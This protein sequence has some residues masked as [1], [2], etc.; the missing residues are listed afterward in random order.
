MMHIP[1]IKIDRLIRSKRKTIALIVR[2]DGTLVVRAP[3]RASNQQI[4][5]FVQEKAKWIEA[6]QELIRL[7]DQKSLHK[8]YVDGEHFLFLGEIYPLEIAIQAD[9]PLSLNQRFLLRAGDRSRAEHLFEAWYREKAS[10]VINARA[11]QLAIRHGFVYNRVK[12]TSARTRW[13]SCTSH[14]NLCFTWR[15]VMAPLP[16]IDYVVIHELA[17]LRQKNHSRTFWELV[18]SLMPDYKIY[19]A[20]LKKNGYLLDL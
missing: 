11:Q 20:W 3:S 4:E 5:R 18:G 1:M 9:S 16:V 13:G 15:L 10:E 17:H 12:I 14:R 7:T 19:R 6:K 2:P 8:S